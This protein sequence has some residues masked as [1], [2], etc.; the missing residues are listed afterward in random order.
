MLDHGLG[1]TNLVTR[2]T[3]RADELSPAELR[4][5]A[6]RT[7]EVV[8]ASGPAWLAVLGVGAYRAAFGRA[9]AQPGPQPERIGTTRVW[10]LPNPSGLNAH[11]QLPDLVERFG[12]LRAALVPGRQVG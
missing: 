7:R 11:H 5:G 10:L 6:E 8:R 4:T 1:C 3:A 2:A 12:K 9:A